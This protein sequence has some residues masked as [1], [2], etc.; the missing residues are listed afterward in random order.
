MTRVSLSLTFQEKDLSTWA[1]ESLPE[2]LSSAF[3]DKDDERL[4]SFRIFMNLY[5]IL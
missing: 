3:K 5:E 4:E 2:Y 1:K